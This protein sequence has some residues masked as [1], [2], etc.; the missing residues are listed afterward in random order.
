VY[1]VRLGAKSGNPA[2]PSVAS[3]ASGGLLATAG[4]HVSGK[5]TQERSN[6]AIGAY[7]GAQAGLTLSNAGNKQALKAP[8]ETLSFQA[9]WG[10]GGSISVTLSHGSILSVNIGVGYGFGLSYADIKTVT[11]VKT[12]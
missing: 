11:G 2:K 7:I 8:S 4:S 6:T 10:Y 5:P 3:T 1:Q 12:W 9:G